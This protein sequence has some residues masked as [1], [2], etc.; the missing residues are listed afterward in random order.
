LCEPA[1]GRTHQLRVHLNTIGHPILGDLHYGKRFRCAWRPERHLL[2]AYSIRFPHPV[3]EKEIEA[4]API[5]QDFLLA[6]EELQID[7]KYS[8]LHF[9]KSV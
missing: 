9:S 5:P 7:V 2:H 6:C 4:I 1:T 8:K 3:H